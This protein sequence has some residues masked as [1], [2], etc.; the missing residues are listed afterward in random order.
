MHRAVALRAASLFIGL[1]LPL[2]AF[3]LAFQVLP[4]TS[5]PWI[6]ET[7]H[8]NPV[9]RFQAGKAFTWSMFAHFAHVRRG[10]TNNEGFI[11]PFD[12]VT[13]EHRPPGAPPL[14]AVIGDSF[15]EA[16]MVPLEA[17]LVSRLKARLGNRGD[18]Y[19][20]GISGAPMSQYLVWADYARSR[21]RPDAM[22]VSIVSNDFD[23]SILAYKLAS[24]PGSSRGFHYFEPGDGTLALTLIENRASLARRI[25]R[26][27][28]LVRYLYMNGGVRLDVSLLAR[29]GLATPDTPAEAASM[30]PRERRLRRLFPVA[31]FEPFSEREALSRRAVDAFLAALPARA[32]LPPQRI[33]LTIDA[34]RVSILAPDLARLTEASL[35]GR[36]RVYL[37]TAARAAG[38]TV[39]DLDPTMRAFVRDTGLPVELG[40][41]Y[42]WN[43]HGHRIAANEIA[44]TGVFRE[45]F[46]AEVGR[47]RALPGQ[48]AGTGLAR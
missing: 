48:P 43:E 37:T 36:M 42:H 44:R 20:F 31:E 18:V 21:F 26:S 6:E 11:A 46:P 13:A 17:S 12:Y 28:A 47:I 41:D 5:G 34:L 2:L 8:D 30:S 19:G 32:G 33:I 45:L 22:V 10:A 24:D 27:S 16:L 40:D 4:V 14:V 35:F 3:E 25:G 38:F 29:L 39:V 9:A 7:S 23:E 15:V 1:L